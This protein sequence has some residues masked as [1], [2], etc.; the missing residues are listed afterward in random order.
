MQRRCARDLGPGILYKRRLERALHC[1][2]ITEGY[3]QVAYQ[4]QVAG[5]RHFEIG[6]DI[7]ALVCCKWQTCAAEITTGGRRGK[8]CERL[9]SAPS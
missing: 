3:G 7:A 8:D 2:L 9:Q 5:N 1:V 4:L 6:I